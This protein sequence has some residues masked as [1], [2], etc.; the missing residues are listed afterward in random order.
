M[1]PIVDAGGTHRQWVPGATAIITAA[2]SLIP[3][4]RGVPAGFPAASDIMA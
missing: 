1:R 2:A 3:R 4:R